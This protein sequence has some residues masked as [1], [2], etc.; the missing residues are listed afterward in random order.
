MSKQSVAKKQQGYVPR[1]EPKRCGNCAHLQFDTKHFTIFGS[2]YTED[3]N[4][5]CGVGQFAVKKLGC[6]N[7]HEHKPEP[8]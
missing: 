2:D 7:I 8:A 5:R 4:F 6:C 3:A 1:V